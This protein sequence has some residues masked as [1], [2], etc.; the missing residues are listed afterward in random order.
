MS[1]LAGTRRGQA[2]LWFLVTLGVV[3]VISG[4][5]V[6]ITAS[7]TDKHALGPGWVRAATL[8]EVRTEGV[9]YVA[10]ADAF[11]VANGADPLA[12]SALNPHLGERVLFCPTSDWFE[13]P[14]DGSKFD[15]F[16]NYGLGPSPRGLDRIAITILDGAVW[17]DPTAVT[18]GPARFDATPSPPT[19]QFCQLGEGPEPA[20][21]SDGQVHHLM[22]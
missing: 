16:G 2:L 15:R 13:S 8:A 21:P 9:V 20:S 19:G 10:S 11:V 18:P 7:R 12:L 5:V 22:P 17:I 1:E 3:G 6:A 4:A 14:G